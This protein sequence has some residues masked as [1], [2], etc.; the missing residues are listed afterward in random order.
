MSL[1]Q[2]N[3]CTQHFVVSDEE[4]H[5]DQQREA[6]A[7]RIHTVLFVQLAHFLLQVLLARIAHA[8]LLIFLLDSLHF[9]LQLL[10]L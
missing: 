5:L 10:H 4:R 1:A 3:G 8:V 2:L 9:R 6:A 7:H